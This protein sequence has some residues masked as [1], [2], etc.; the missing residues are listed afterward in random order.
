M[1]KNFAWAA[2]G[3]LFTGIAAGTLVGLLRSGEGFVEEVGRAPASQAPAV[4]TALTAVRGRVDVPAPAASQAPQ[5]TGAPNDADLARIVSELGI[6]QQHTRI[7]PFFPD[8]EPGRALVALTLLSAELTNPG[9][10]AGRFGNAKYRELAEHPEEAF[11]TVSSV[12]AQIPP[13]LFP[14]KRQFL[15]QF[16][17]DL[18][19]DV[20]AKADFLLTEAKTA[21]PSAAGREPG[22][23]AATLTPSVA[24]DCHRGRSR[25]SS[26]SSSP[27]STSA[28]GFP[29][30]ARSA[31]HHAPSESVH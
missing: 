11:Q 17:A 5:G 31:S 7:A 15:I 8:T 26:S 2:A 4:A 1:N 30:A 25:M 23:A 14:D 29:A 27:S 10:V 20:E 9:S 18:D 3:S 24:M 21:P 12:L 16:A 19:V 13:S 28:T 22:S 6:N